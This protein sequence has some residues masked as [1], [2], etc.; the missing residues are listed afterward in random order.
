MYYTNK[1]TPQTT[2]T[3]T[4]LLQGD[5]TLAFTATAQQRTEPHELTST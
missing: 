3:T 5:P 4:S 1:T 2:T